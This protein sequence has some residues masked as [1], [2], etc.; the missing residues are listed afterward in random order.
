MLLKSELLGISHRQEY[1][2]YMDFGS[3]YSSM[4]GSS[5]SST[6]GNGCGIYNYSSSS[7]SSGA[8]GSS[9]SSSMGFSGRSSGS[10]SSNI[11]RF[12]APRQSIHDEIK[13]SISFNGIGCSSQRY[14]NS[15]VNGAS[16][17]IVVI[18]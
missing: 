12:K 5:S 9:S 1:T 8:Y 15:C 7:S 17:T 14:G 13:T 4:G 3:S 16:C 6:P 18:C 11:L 10:A 2:N